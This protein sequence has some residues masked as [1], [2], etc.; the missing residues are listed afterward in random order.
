[1]KK[2]VTEDW[3]KTYL[4]ERHPVTWMNFW[5][6]KTRKIDSGW[7]M[8]IIDAYN[9][10]IEVLHVKD[11]KME[12]SLTKIREGTLKNVSFRHYG[13]VKCIFVNCNFIECDFTASNMCGNIFVNCSFKDCYYAKHNKYAKMYNNEF[14][15]CNLQEWIEEKCITNPPKKDGYDERN[16]IY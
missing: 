3:I 7:G 8:S 15:S 9:A 5:N 4:K 6:K 13:I 10:E 2:E 16:R 14:H 12:L 1:M 11:I